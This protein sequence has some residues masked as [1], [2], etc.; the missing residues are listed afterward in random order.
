MAYGQPAL[1]PNPFLEPESAPRLTVEKQHLVMHRA[2]YQ[3]DVRAPRLSLSLPY[4]AGAG[5]MVHGKGGPVQP[6]RYGITSWL[7][8]IAAWTASLL[9]VAGW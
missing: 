7:R 8:E 3:E 2:S 1:T 6:P 5:G 9:S 4:G